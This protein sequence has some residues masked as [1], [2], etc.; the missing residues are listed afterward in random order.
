LPGYPIAH[1]GFFIPYARKF[2]NTPGVSFNM[3]QRILIGPLGDAF[4][5]DVKKARKSIFVWTINDEETMKWSI[6]KEVDGVIT[7]DPK[8]YLKIRETY[9]GEEVSLYLKLLEW[10][11]CCRF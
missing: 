10:I 3:F 11:F 9:Q 5:R 1:I 6:Y 8:K 4:L 7:D 2:L